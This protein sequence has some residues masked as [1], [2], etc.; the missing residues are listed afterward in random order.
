MATEFVD[1]SVRGQAVRVPALRLNGVIV[2]VTGRWIKRAAIKDEAWLADDVIVAPDVI[3]ARLKA[4]ALGAD[5]FTFSQKLPCTGPKYSYPLAWSNVAAIP[6]TSY[7]D[8]WENRLPQVARKNVRRAAKRGVTVR[9]VAF[10]D[11]LVEAIVAINNETPIRQGRPFWHYGKSFDAVKKDYSDFLDRSEYLGAYYQDELVGFIRL[12]YV[13]KT[14]SILQLLCKN[15]HYD[16]RPANALIAKAVELCIEKGSSHLSYGQ[17]V[18]GGNT[19]SL[20]TDFKRR[21]GFEQVLIPTYYVPLTVKG[22][23]Y[24]KSGMHLGIKRLIPKRLL[25]ILTEFRS[26][27]YH[28]RLAKTEAADGAGQSVDLEAEA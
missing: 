11:A 18:Y 22:W 17:Y 24:V 25:Y 14:A 23:V 21:N 4:G 16:K 15:K 7:A 5:V 8:W 2:T 10:S 19:N 27:L 20:L 12:V 13:G 26:R 1:I 6:L 28:R 3:V 9:P